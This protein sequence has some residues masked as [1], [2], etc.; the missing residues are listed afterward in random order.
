MKL[1]IPSHYNNNK[2]F[3]KYCNEVEKQ[4]FLEEKSLDLRLLE[5]SNKDKFGH[6][7]GLVFFFQLFQLL[8]K[9][10]NTMSPR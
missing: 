4:Q 6:L 10:Q 2:A 7:T 5:K 9:T 1:R 8:E 3:P